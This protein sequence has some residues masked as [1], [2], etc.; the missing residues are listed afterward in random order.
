[1]SFN[2]DGLKQAQKVVFSLNRNKPFNPNIIFD[3]NLVKQSLYKNKS[4]NIWECFFIINLILKN[5]FKVY[6]IKLVNVFGLICK[7]QNFSPILL[8]PQI[9]YLS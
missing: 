6:V 1:M 7:P 9:T 2:A 4:K 3:V 8:L 5:I